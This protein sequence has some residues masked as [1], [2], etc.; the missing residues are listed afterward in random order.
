MYSY[1][2]GTIR[3]MSVPGFIIWLVLLLGS[4]GGFV[5]GAWMWITGDYENETVV[6]T[7]PL[8]CFVVFLA[9]TIYK[10]T[11]KQKLITYTDVLHV[12]FVDQ[13]RRAYVVHLN[14]DAFLNATG[15]SGYKIQQVNHRRKYD[16]CW[17][18]HGSHGYGSQGRQD[19]QAKGLFAEADPGE[20]GFFRR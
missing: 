6:S 16:A 19:D 8:V 12:V 7:L 17:T 4:I 13:A 9:V 2:P 11:Y 10:S 15:L 5:Y 1:P 20:A 3:N 18:I 14:E